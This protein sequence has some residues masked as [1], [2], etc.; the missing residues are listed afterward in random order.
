MSRLAGLRAGITA[1]FLLAGCASQ[2]VAE[3]RTKTDR[4]AMWR[5]AD[6]DTTI[7]LFGTFHMLPK[8]HA[9]RTPAFDKALA[10]SNELVLEIANVGDQAAAGAAMMK[11][12]ISPG[13]PPLIERVPEAKRAALQAFID[14][15]GIPVAALDR[16][17]TWA[18]ALALTGVTF[19]RLGISGDQGVESTLSTDVKASG[20]PI[21]GLETVEQQLGY[22][23]ALSEESQRLFLEGVLD[24]PEDVRREFQKMLDAW[25][26]GDEAGVAASFDEE[27]S[28]SPE[29]REALLGARNRRWAE[30]LD[31]RMDQP[32]TVFVAVGAGHLAGND[33]VQKMLKSRGI[34]AVRIQ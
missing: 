34:K 18:A 23:D 20:K 19:K 33:S 16:L 29:L 27:A 1:A 7:Y 13:L 30:W 32:G 28:L 22:F 15:S 3:P 26:R 12:G 5:V 9:W 11:L 10:S 2:S 31:A 17:E 6:S 24:S 4:P 8:D 21:R 25:S 14:E